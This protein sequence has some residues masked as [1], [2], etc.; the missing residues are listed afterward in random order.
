MFECWL[1][2]FFLL[3]VSYCF[4]WLVSFSL[5]FSG[6]HCLGE[7]TRQVGVLVS[8]RTLSSWGLKKTLVHC[9][10]ALFWLLPWSLILDEF[11]M[12][13]VERNKWIRIHS[14]WLLPLPGV[15]KDFVSTEFT[16]KAALFAGGT[17][18]ARCGKHSCLFRVL[19]LLSGLRP[20]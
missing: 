14:P 9:Y 16:Q 1:S 10:L 11:Y 17:S 19:A 7:G 4:L 5:V 12:V 6:L 15:L 2:S 3:A 13:D 8:P 20:L 18:P